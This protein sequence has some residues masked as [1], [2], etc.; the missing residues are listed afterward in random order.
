MTTTAAYASCI[1]A[2]LAFDECLTFEPGEQVQRAGET[3][4]R[5]K[6]AEASG[7]SERASRQRARSSLAPQH[8]DLGVKPCGT[9]LGIRES[10]KGTVRLPNILV[11]KG[12]PSSPFSR[13]LVSTCASFRP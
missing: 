13:F 12:P 5:G 9:R 10:E 8:Y 1:A 11:L 7:Q 6:Q 2:Y 3:R 4:G